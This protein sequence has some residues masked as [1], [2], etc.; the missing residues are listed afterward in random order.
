MRTIQICSIWRMESIRLVRKNNW[1]DT[2]LCNIG[3]SILTLD[4][5]MKRTINRHQLEFNYKTWRPLFCWWPCI[6]FI[7]IRTC[8]IKQ[9]KQENASHIALKIYAAKA[10]IMKLNTTNR[11]HVK[12]KDEQV[13]DTFT[14]RML[15]VSLDCSFLFLHLPLRYSLTFIYHGG[16]VS[17][18]EGCDEDIKNSLGKAKG[19]LSSLRKNVELLDIFHKDKN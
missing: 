9:R 18:K 3:M 7:Q 12:I 10:K 5:I 14:Y 11:E 13:Q 17:S 16:V 15:P 19:Q 8:T 4:Y 2:M 1:S 6:D